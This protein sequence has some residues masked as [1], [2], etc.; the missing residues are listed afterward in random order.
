MGILQKIVEEK[1]KKLSETK[2]KISLVDLVSKLANLKMPVRDF[3]KAISVPQNKLHVIAELKKSS[4]SA[5]LI[6]EDYDPVKIAKSYQALKVDAIS[7]LTE[8]KYFQGDVEHIS[9]VRK[10]TDVPLL[11][12]D[13]I[14]DPYQIYES[15]LE[16][17]DAILLIA[18]LL[19][20]H[21]IQ[22]FLDV[23]EG[24]GLHCLVEVHSENDLQKVLDTSAKIIGINN[25]NLSTLKV[26]IKTTEKLRSKIPKGHVVVSESGIS[27]KEDIKMLK[28]LG[29]NAI[30]IGHYLLE[31]R[32]NI[33]KA[34]SEIL[35]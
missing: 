9:L 29:I 4:P 15:R 5:G 13:F 6:I 3:A 10:V 27:S 24:I 19:F 22:K 17:A 31:K 16:G 11:R 35:N 18:S 25:R 20:K 30:L 32:E 26:D 8:E 21:E 28:K 14:I 1:K 34:L 12:K 33:G 2:E 23:A 7:V